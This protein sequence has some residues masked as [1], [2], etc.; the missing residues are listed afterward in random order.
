[1]SEKFEFF[2]AGVQ[3]H[4]A[5]TVINEIEVGDEILMEPEPS[6]KYDPNAIKLMYGDTM[7]GYVP[8]KFSGSVSAFLETADDPICEITYVNPKAKTYEQ[9]KVII[10]DYTEEALEDVEEDEE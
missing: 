6:N 2:I 5:K 4:Q 3:F 9:L 8:A 7:L 1:M 10:K